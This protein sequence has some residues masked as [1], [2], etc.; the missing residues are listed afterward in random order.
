MLPVDAVVAGEI[1]E[2]ARTSVVD[3][4]QVGGDRMILDVGPETAR[5]FADAAETRSTRPA[6]GPER[7]DENGGIRTVPK[8]RA[9]AFSP[10][11]SAGRPFGSFRSGTDMQVSPEREA[12]VRRSDDGLSPATEPAGKGKT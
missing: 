3:V 8:K 4:D 2:D 10:Q 6:L 5:R 1:A 9:L 7:S 11:R 12:P